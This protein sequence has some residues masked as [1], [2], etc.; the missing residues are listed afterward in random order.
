MSKSN[1]FQKGKVCTKCGKYKALIYYSQDGNGGFR[2]DCKDCAAS[3]QRDIRKTM[4]HH[5]VEQKTCA[6]CGRT[7]PASEF[8][9]DK[10]KVDG[11]C[12]HCKE[13]KALAYKHRNRM[14]LLK[15]PASKLY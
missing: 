11:L 10:T 8:S 4:K 14:K 5:P 13:C 1:V 12:S 7:K 15:N 9:R 2:S 6:R 3:Q